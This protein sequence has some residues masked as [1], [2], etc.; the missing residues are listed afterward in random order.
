MVGRFWNATAESLFYNVARLIVYIVVT[1]QVARVMVSTAT[2]LHILYS[3][4]IHFYFAIANEIVYEI[5]VMLHF[6]LI[7]SRMRSSMKSV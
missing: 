3:R 2:R 6:I 4:R 5:S 7:S 1:S